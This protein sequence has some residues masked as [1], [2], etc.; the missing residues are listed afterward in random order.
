MLIIEVLQ[1]YQIPKIK[2]DFMEDLLFG[3]LILLLTEFYY[4]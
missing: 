1:K 2:Q 4:Y 3:G